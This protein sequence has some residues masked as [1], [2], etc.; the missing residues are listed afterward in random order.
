MQT[1]DLPA[2][3]KLGL[4]PVAVH[5]GPVALYWYGLLV[6]A[7]F[8]VA[9]R[10]ASREAERQ[11]LDADQLLSAALVGALVGLLMAR[12]FYVLQN[13]PGAY[14]DPKQ[15]A[16]ALSLWQ[17]GLSFYGGL[18][19]GMLGVWLFTA[20]N[21]LPTLRYLDIAALVAPL[22]QAIGRLGN[23]VNGDLTGLPTYSRGIE[24]TNP[25]NPL[26]PTAALGRTQH[27]VAIYDVVFELGLFAL[28]FYFWRKRPLRVGQLSGLYLAGWATG[29]L[30]LQSWRDLPVGLGGLKV[31]QLTALPIIAGGLYLYFRSAGAAPAQV[32]AHEPAEQVEPAEVGEAETPV[33][34]P[35]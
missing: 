35:A 28:L 19:G 30:F 25:A 2:C 13:T 29:Q 12:V 3:F 20:R 15:L 31:T 16:T 9:I 21:S 32:V 10:L 8:V 4:D 26:V 33:S 7:G 23:V 27:P 1:C 24:Y 34:D 17:G 22:G 18:F 11:G 14:L 6:A 5:L